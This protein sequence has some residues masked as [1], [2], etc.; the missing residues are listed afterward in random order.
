MLFSGA[1]S[2]HSWSLQPFTHAPWESG[3]FVNAVGDGGSAAG[4]TGTCEEHQSPTAFTHVPWERVRR[5]N[6]FGPRMIPGSMRVVHLWR[7]KWAAL[8][9]LLVVP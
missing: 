4:T 9:G 3:T 6:A 2:A 7:A 5:T 1:L 8:S